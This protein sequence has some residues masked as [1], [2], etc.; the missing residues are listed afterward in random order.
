ME[1]QRDASSAGK[2]ELA[3]RDALPVAPFPGPDQKS[4][5]DEKRKA[6]APDGYR[7]RIR[8]R[9]PHEGTRERDADQRE[10]EYP[11]RFRRHAK[12]K[13]PVRE[14]PALF[15]GQPYSVFGVLTSRISAAARPA[16]LRTLS[17]YRW[18]F[19]V[20]RPRTQ[21]LYRSS[22]TRVLGAL[23]IASLRI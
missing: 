11:V 15:S 3:R 10:R 13:E 18:Q 8:A 20:L 22:A 4:G 12:K 23:R 2:G 17:S 19:G 6:E 21:P 9:K 7:H 1:R 16:C 5:N 14:A